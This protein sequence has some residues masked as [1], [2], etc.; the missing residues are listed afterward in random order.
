MDHRPNLSTQRRLL[1]RAVNNRLAPDGIWHRGTRA[2]AD[3]EWGRVSEGPEPV[4]TRRHPG[5]VRHE[6]C[7]RGTAPDCTCDSLGRVSAGANSRRG[8]VAG[9]PACRNIFNLQANLSGFGR[10]LPASMGDVTTGSDAAEK[11]DRHDW[12]VD[13]QEVGDH[14]AGASQY[15]RRVRATGRQWAMVA[16]LCVVFALLEF[17]GRAAGLGAWTSPL[18]FVVWILALRRMFNGRFLPARKAQLTDGSE[19]P[20]SSK[21]RRSRAEQPAYAS[22]NDGSRPGRTRECAAHG[23][24]LG[25]WVR[26][27][28]KR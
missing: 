18:I 26:G 11:L 1:I 10:L 2:V 24:Q 6:R 23:G 8:W 27:D 21:T 5:S 13:P 17:V 15:D 20:S 9:E 3:V 4:T 28:I 7:R 19:A 16:A 22:A 25:R 12:P 14:R